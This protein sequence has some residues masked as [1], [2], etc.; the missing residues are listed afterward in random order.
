AARAMRADDKAGAEHAEVRR[1]I[2]SEFRFAPPPAAQE[3]L[4][5]V[6]SA[7]A[8]PGEPGAQQPG[9]SDIVTM[10][11]YTVRETAR[12][13][14]LHADIAREHAAAVTAAEMRRLGVGIHDVQVGKL[15]LL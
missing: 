11:S 5:P 8:R 13:G 15:H 14:E 10:E 6:L 3:V 12:M 1:Q 7:A 4:P 2:L 9:G